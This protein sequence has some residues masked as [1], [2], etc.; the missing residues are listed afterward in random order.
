M[1]SSPVSTPVR[2]TH[3]G[4]S[5][6]GI[7]C[8]RRQRVHHV[9]D[10]HE[11]AGHR[12]IAPDFDR[13]AVQRAGAQGDLIGS[14]RVDDAQHLEVRPVQMAA[15]RQ[16]RD[17]VFPDI[18]GHIQIGGPRHG[19]V[20]Q[21]E[22]HVERFDRGAG[23][24]GGGEVA[25]DP[26]EAALGLGEQP[27]APERAHA[28]AGFS[29]PPAESGADEPAAAEHDAGGLSNDHQALGIGREP[30]CYPHG[31]SATA[32]RPAMRPKARHSPRLPVP[33]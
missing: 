11:V 23:R 16:R 13:F 12:P 19:G 21:M 14:V 18:A 15:Q 25:R 10:K 33:W 24:R 7:G 4:V 5:A 28:V 22:H 1:R 20:N 27:A 17:Y 31:I 8:R 26:V 3:P 2:G 32:L 29:Q 9:P 30:A 6:A